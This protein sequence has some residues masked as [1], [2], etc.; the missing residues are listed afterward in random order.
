MSVIRHRRAAST[1]FAAVVDSA[2]RR[3]RPNTTQQCAD[4]TLFAEPA[5]RE[6]RYG[7]GRR[8]CSMPS[9]YSLSLPVSAVDG[10][11]NNVLGLIIYLRH[12]RLFIYAE[13]YRTVVKKAAGSGNRLPE[14]PTFFCYHKYL[15][16]LFTGIRSD[17][18]W[19][20]RRCSVYLSGGR[21][22]VS[23]STTYLRSTVLDDNPD[24]RGWR[25][26]VGR[27]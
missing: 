4:K 17:D 24:I 2:A 23:V 7:A 14:F 10:E 9:G 5:R 1:L 11:R 3:R 20:R 15:G 26:A 21:T 27:S 8:R 16:D 13:C 22:K 12:S 19:L 25:C 6:M 18:W